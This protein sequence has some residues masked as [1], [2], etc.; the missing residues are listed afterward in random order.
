MPSRRRRIL[1][2]EWWRWSLSLPA[3]AG[4]PN[5]CDPFFDVTLGQSG[6]VWFLAAP[7]GT[8]QRSIAI[9]QG[10]KL[11]IAIINVEAS[12]IEVAPFDG[13]TV[14]EQAVNAT[15]FANYIRQ[16]YF[17]LNGKPLA[18]LGRFRFVSPQFSL[19]LPVPNVIGI[20]AGTS[21]PCPFVPAPLPMEMKGVSDGFWVMLRPLPLGQ[22]TIRVGGEFQNTPFGTFGIDMT[23]DV[24]VF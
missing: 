3:V 1:R 15:A 24:T 10:T 8:C 16:P 20:P 11:F 23:Y 14:A 18:K 21:S 7:F 2:C 17:E 12:S 4:H 19:T 13:C 9:P 5:Y 6:N 22:H